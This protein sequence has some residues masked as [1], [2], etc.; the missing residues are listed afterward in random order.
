M[1]K[2][3]GKMLFL[4]LV[5][6]NIFGSS[7][8][9]KVSSLAIY[10]GDIVN[11]EI[12]ANGSDVEFP[13]IV[14]IKGYPIL[15]NSSSSST[16]IING[17]I[18]KSIS[19][20][21]S[22]RPTK[23][24]TIPSF[25]IKIDGK[26]FTTKKKQIIV[27]KPQ[28]SK[29]GDKFIVELKIANKDLKV[30]QSSRLTIIFRQR[31]D[32]RADKMSLD[33]PKIEN[34][35]IK[36]ISGIKKYSK[37]QYMVQEINY[38][39]FAQKSGKYHVDPIE[40]S[41]GRLIQSRNSFFNDPFFNSISRQI[42]WNKIY[43]NALDIKVDPLPDNIELYGQF[44][45]SATVDKKEIFA[46]K[47]VNLT[48]NINGT[49]NIDDI[50]K[51]DLNIDNAVVYADKPKIN[52]HIQNKKY[53]GTFSQKIAIIADRSFIIPSIQLTYF[54]ELTKT[55]KIIKTKSINIKVNGSKKQIS[56]KIEK[57]QKNQKIK[58]KEKIIYKSDK[59]EY[60][61]FVLGLIFGVIIAYFIFIKQ[62]KKK[63]ER[64]SPLVLSIKNAKKDKE[65]FDILLPYSNDSIIVSNILK[66]L[67]D[68]I[69][70]KTDHKIDK[71]LLYDIFL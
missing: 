58:I 8:E 71:Q 52:A 6:T 41:I 9:I 47:P 65:L 67:E 45:I 56:P 10:S 11:F 12:K 29:D 69:Y 40:A 68:N 55:V 43:S 16:S 34:F 49:G 32:A 26:N 51:F 63:I 62:N 44:N 22:F 39:I 37:G 42:K 7:V 25:N 23:T 38:L 46:N 4:I 61:Y 5:T 57:N 30:G 54:D 3:L 1:K 19:K 14:D 35:W 18:K 59:L 60:L 21:Y 36:K 28:R 20:T 48:I 33:D 15:G 31:L 13:Q 70:K 66:K 64:K 24:V 2:I 50:E 17:D 27:V 53:I